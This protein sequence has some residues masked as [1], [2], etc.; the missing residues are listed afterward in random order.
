M[1]ILII[2]NTATKGYLEKPQLEQ[3]LLRR[4][5]LLCFLQQQPQVLV[6]PS[7][8]PSFF[9]SQPQGLFHWVP[10]QQEWH[11]SRHP[12]L[13]SPSKNSVMIITYLRKIEFFNKKNTE[14][15]TF[16]I[17]HHY[18]PSSLFYPSSCPVLFEW[19]LQSSSLVSFLAFVTCSPLPKCK[20]V[21]NVKSKKVC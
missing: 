11:L 8:R 18:S 19:E 13:A 14:K 20:D 3:N 7:C 5:L 21:N 9:L 6:H 4:V 2:F 15:L 1:A 17:K 16:N 10:D 12:L